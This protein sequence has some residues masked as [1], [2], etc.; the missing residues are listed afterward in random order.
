ML[1][2]SWVA[3]RLA[4][5]QDEL[6]VM[7]IC[8]R[9]LLSSNLGGDT[10]DHGWGFRGLHQSLQ[11]FTRVLFLWGHDASFQILSIS[12]F[13]LSIMKV[14]L[15]DPETQVAHIRHV[16]SWKTCGRKQTWANG[17]GPFL[18]S[19]QRFIIVFTRALHWSLSWARSIQSILPHPISL[20]SILI[21][22]TH[23]RLSSQWSLSFWL[24]H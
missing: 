8:I 1:E 17:V 23:L 2:N 12:A 22:S 4:A 13:I 18:R 16:E 21:L 10:G 3:E 7:Y 20:R 5:S 15:N 19:C 14:S 6:R 24:S 11:A 9:K